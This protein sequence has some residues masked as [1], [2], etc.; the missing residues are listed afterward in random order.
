MTIIAEELPSYTYMWEKCPE[1][2]DWVARCLEIPDL[3]A[4]GE[5]DEEALTEIKVA[6]CG[7]LE[8]L[9]E[10]GLP[11]PSPLYSFPSNSSVSE[12]EDLSQPRTVPTRQSHIASASF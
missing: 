6:V 7:W 9:K 10:D 11:F 3:S 12:S 4:Y 2:G 1:S 8:V 5:T